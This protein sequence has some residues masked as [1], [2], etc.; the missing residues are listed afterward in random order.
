MNPLALLLAMFAAVAGALGGGGSSSRAEPRD[1]DD[2]LGLDPL[3][4]SS[5][6]PAPVKPT[7]TPTP[8]PPT[9]QEPPAPAP[10]P[11]PVQPTPVPPPSDPAP[12]PPP[13]DPTPV[14]P[15]S[16]PVPPPPPPSDPVPP[17]PPPPPPPGDP[18]PQPP[19]Q[20]GGGGN[21]GASTDPLV[22]PT[23]VTA[24]RVATIAPQGGD[25]VI[26]VRILQHPNHGHLSVN[27]DNTLALVMTE[28]NHTGSL[29]FRYETTL[30]N[31]STATHTTSLNVV[32]GPQAGGWATGQSHY[33]LET[34]DAG[35]IIVEHGDNHRPV[36]V[37]GS[38]DALTRA[39]I[40]QIAGV[41]IS[42]VTPQWL[43]ARPEFGGSEDMALAQDVGRDLWRHITQETQSSNWLL[44]ESGHTYNNWMVVEHE[45]GGESALHPL[46]IGSYGDG[47]RPILTAGQYVMRAGQE[48]IVFQ[49]LH[50]TGGVV[51]L[52]P[53]GNMIID[54]TTFTSESLV[55]QDVPGVTVRN[56]NFIDIY[57][58]T[59]QNSGAFW[60]VGANRTSGFYVQGVEGLLIEG[61]FF[62]QI[63]WAQDYRY[64]TSTDG[65][66]PPSMF[67][68]GLY[69][70]YDNSDVTLRDT[71]IMRSASYGVQV[72]PGGFIEG[73]V[74]LDNNIGM[75]VM[76]GDAFDR[77]PTGQ[78]SLVMDNVITSA[79]HKEVAV[80]EG[81]LSWGLM[82]QARMTSL[83]DNIVAHM[84]DPNN[85]VE[86][87]A[88]T[89]TG[90]ALQNDY[91]P[92]YNDTAIWNWIGSQ[93]PGYDGPW[94]N[95]NVDGLNP[96]VLDQTTIQNFTA[97]LLGQETATI[98][99][100]ANY[101]RAQS[102][103][104]FDNVVDADLI[105]RFFQVGFGIAPD[106]RLTADTLR[107]V[108]NDV[109][110][111]VRWDNRLNWD[112]QDLPGSVA[113][114]S[115][116]L[117]GNR[118]IY[119]GTTRVQDL[120]FGDRGSLSVSHGRLTVEDDL[121][122]GSGRASLQ[123][124]NTGQFWTDGLSG[125]GLLDIDQTGG[126]FVNTGEFRG[127][128]DMT[129]NGGQT[130]LATDDATFALTAGSRLEIVGSAGRVGFDG[131]QGGLAILGLGD[132]STLVF[133]AANG[134]L[135]T[136]GEFRSGAFGDAPNVQSGI[137]LGNA[138][139]QIDLRGISG[140]THNF[141][142]MQ[143]DELIGSLENASFIGLGS[144]NAEIVIDYATDT[145]TLGLTSGNGTI[146]I[147]A[148]GTEDMVSDG[149]QDLWAALT[150]GRGTWDETAP[151]QEEEDDLDVAA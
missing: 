148:L 63:G 11:A 129:L 17:P 104:A 2:A 70:Q 118:V 103:G 135:G 37:S 41:P 33:M 123:I 147:R 44:L 76:G 52:P 93:P 23:T 137:D 58:E 112:T 25:D 115:V 139:L 50:F 105:T 80:A 3:P 122:V 83:V 57:E 144:R 81:A 65:G 29:S 56:S 86:Q 67:S 64:D 7:P 9:T 45:A 149:Y 102:N 134:Q 30:A 90:P 143:V 27:P 51:V 20:S 35:D 107:F 12:T 117:G 84:A 150:A 60:D 24:G 4:D 47:A 71:I 8:P 100:L 55:V 22:N 53:A 114:D 14:P 124:S 138:A 72:R 32:A 127:Q 119:G 42:Q 5:G 91:T 98:A 73:N 69:I 16:D 66:H 15:P 140:S 36:Y 40:A 131:D 46:Y 87:A 97:Q 126:R 31:G 18:A 75:N 121:T 145:V 77:G 92:Y 39:D 110:E 48:N 28:S 125:P 43:A 136:I 109:G 95:T 146:G 74:L 133:T 61:N 141:T 94:L 113:G 62:D 85:P 6:A 49:G 108:P 88:K 132:D 82:N 78:Y 130:I 99:D 1:D 19:P 10:A 111:G 120:E 151:V 21:D 101:L 38:S 142:L 128:T 34:N 59:P 54:D 106:I 13:S 26:S 96:A 116:D 89:T 68:H 79:S